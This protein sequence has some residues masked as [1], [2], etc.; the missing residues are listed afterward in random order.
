MPRVRIPPGPPFLPS[1]LPEHHLYVRFPGELG[2]HLLFR[3]YL[4]NHPEAARRH[5]DLRNSLAT[6]FGDDREGYSELAKGSYAMR[7]VDASAR[8]LGTSEADWLIRQ[9]LGVRTHATPGE[10]VSA[11]K[12]R[13]QGSEFV[14]RVRGPVAKRAWGIFIVFLMVAAPAKIPGGLVTPTTSTQQPI[15][16]SCLDG[17][18]SGPLVPQN[19]SVALI[20]PIFTSTPYSQYAYGSFYAF[21]KRYLGAR[22]NITTNLDWLNTSVKS[23]MGYSSGWGHT[24]PLYAFLVSAAARGCGLVLGKN[25]RLI[26]DINVSSGALF[27][28]GG[29]RRYDA[30]IIGHQEYV[31]QSEYDQLRLFVAAGGRLVAMSSDEFYGKVKF[32]PA[33]LAETFITGHGGYAFNGRTAWYNKTLYQFP[34]NTSG[35]FGS[36]YCCFHRFT[37]NGGAINRS[38]PI[39]RLEYSLIGATMAPGYRIHEENAVTN[40]TRTSI[41]ATYSVQS[42]VTVS[43][44]VHGYGRGAVFCL[45][46]FGEDMIASDRSTQLFLMAS[47]N[48]TYWLA[49]SPST[50]TTMTQGGTFTQSSSQ[51]VGRGPPA[52]TYAVVAAS[53][54]SA[55]IL[56]AHWLNGRRRAAGRTPKPD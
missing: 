18:A 16:Q 2:A 26:S 38:D 23:G 4:R 56:G 19:L 54:V 22:G 32:N 31:T 49:G 27:D 28:P 6:R 29:G 1:G 46:V 5:S 20:K 48:T 10:P 55:L 41:V 47:L 40:L 13:L 43:S 15:L 11:V 42:G 50:T 7:I 21:Y 9:F 35:W 33:T 30:A 12:T 37:Y 25:L 39:G 53:A 44:Y 34:W 51:S 17:G 14:P 45:C 8:L 52:S 36:T 3:G 24:Y